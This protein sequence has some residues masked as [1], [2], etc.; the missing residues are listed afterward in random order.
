MTL[1][2]SFVVERL[3]NG[4]PDLYSL[5]PFKRAGRHTGSAKTL[6]SFRYPLGSEPILD[7]VSHHRFIFSQRLGRGDGT[8]LA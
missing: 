2:D 5:S 8:S 3:G 7:P 6:V 4:H 1:A